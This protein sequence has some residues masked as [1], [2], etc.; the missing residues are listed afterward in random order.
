MAKPSSKAKKTRPNTGRLRVQNNLAK[1]AAQAVQFNLGERAAG[2][3]PKYDPSFPYLAMHLC[4]INADNPQ[5]AEAFGV[6]PACIQKWIKEY[7]LFSEA[8]KIGKAKT[9]EEVERALVHRAKG[10]SHKAT[11]FFMYE[12]EVI[13]AE[14]TEQYPP[15]TG[16]IAFWLKNRRPDRWRDR[17]AGAIEDPEEAARKVR[18]RLAAID[19]NT[20]GE[21]KKP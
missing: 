19:A 11:K 5:L 8:I 10:Y 7:P 1:A 21:E 9:D 16:A 18:E 12:G 13:Q 6:D 15:D 4:I 2:R 3:P 17:E 14:Y 20:A